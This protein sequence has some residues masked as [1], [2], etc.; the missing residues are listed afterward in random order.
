MAAIASPNQNRWLFGPASDLLLGCGGLYLLAFIAV[1]AIGPRSMEWLP[2]GLIPLALIFAAVPHYGATLLRVYEHSADRRTYALFSIWASALVWGLFVWGVYDLLIGSLLLT[3]YLS[4]SPWHY[5]GQNYGIG[6]LMM[7]RAGVRVSPRAK[8]LLYASFLLSYLLVLFSTHAA[9]PTAN[10]SPTPV[11][12]N[13]SAY[14][15]MPVGIPVDILGPLLLA[16]AAAYAITTIV[17]FAILRRSASWTDLTPLLGVVVLQGIWFAIPV[18]C[19]ATNALQGVFPLSVASVSYMLLWYAFGHSFQYLWVTTY[20]A[21]RAKTDK[22]RPTYWLKSYLAGAS[23]FA[24]PAFLFSPLALGTHSFES[25]LGML[26]ASAVNLHHF[27][28]DGAIWKLR[29]GRIARILLRRSEAG[30]STADTTGS[31]ARRIAWSALG[32]LG[33]AYGV[34]YLVGIWEIEHGFRRAV[35]VD[36]PNVERMR[37]AADRLAF[38]GHDHPGIHLNL[39]ILAVRDGDLETGQREAERSIALGPSV[40]AHLL[41][42][43]IHQQRK[44]WNEARSDYEAALAIDPKQVIALSQSAAVS[45]ELGDFARAEAE[46]AS[47]AALAPTRQD[48]RNRLDLIRRQRAGATKNGTPPAS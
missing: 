23:L 11:S 29:D 17:A 26:I 22:H 25:G 10:Y 36:P 45:A 14:T 31:A 2:E 13:E 24:V 9:M 39:A 6:L 5:S 1:A 3:L 47:A 37:V 8:R 40:R 48:L 32:G 4:W 20:Y 19:R 7:G 18:L 28:L 34:F 16:T 12:F 15:Y 33:V 35:A 38:V 27:V 46:L 30:T 21:T 42:G 44:Q 43:Q 41:L